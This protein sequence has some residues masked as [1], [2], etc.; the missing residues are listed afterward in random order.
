MGESTESPYDELTTQDEVESIMEPGGGAV[1]LDF[2]SETCGPC[3]AMADDFAHVAAQF[4]P[5]EV[6]FCKVNTTEHGWLAAP[7]K[8]RS[9]PT[10]LFIHNGKILD[11]VVGKMS[12]ADL[13]TKAEWLLKKATK[14]GWLSK[15]FS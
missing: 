12:A 4:E 5:G 13:G 3:L 6:R 15:V 11:A 14:K 8:V 7:F 9:V 10:I 1:V 2:W